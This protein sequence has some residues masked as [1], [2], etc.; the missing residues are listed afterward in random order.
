M[1]IQ[2]MKNI[3]YITL[4]LITS[5]FFT[6][7]EEVIDVKLDTAAPR[8]VVEASILWEKGTAGNEQMIKLTTTTD[9][10][11][12]VI[13]SVSNAI[14]FV[15]DTNGH[16]F[17]FI[18]TTP[19]T[20]KY[21]C[22]NFIPIIDGKYDLT[23][24]YANQTY[25]A[26]ETLKSV[27]SFNSN[28]EQNNDGGFLGDDIEIRAYYTDPANIQNNYLLTAQSNVDNRNQYSASEDQFYDGNTI[29]SN[30][31]DEDL[32]PGHIVK[33][34][35]DGISKSYYNY[36]NKLLAIAGTE[37]GGGMFSPPPATI[38]GNLINASNIDN[39]ALGFFRLSETTGINYTV[40]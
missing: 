18:E 19:N 40:Q 35:I 33:F 22:T 10:F 31:T 7:C 37:G 21:Y 4:L 39:Y 32:A 34:R 13:P 26:T 38:R 16:T 6:S 3:K 5:L 24:T 29:F 12:N 1:N 17:N 9:Y 15:T 27:V 23:V 25:T 36:L 28:I 8:L 2:K 20:G 11:N 14:V 30:Y